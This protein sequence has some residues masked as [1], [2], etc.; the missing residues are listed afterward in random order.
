MSHP[1]G[2]DYWFARVDF[3]KK[4][5]R[6]GEVTLD[7]MRE[8]LDRLGNPQDYLR[9]AHVAGTKGKGSTAAMLESI[10]RAAGLRTGLFT[11]P[12]LTRVHERIRLGSRPIADDDLAV[13]LTEIRPAIESLE[14]EGRPPTFFEIATALAYHQ[15]AK[16]AVDLAVMEVG[17]GGRFDATNVCRPVVCVITSVSYD[18]TAILGDRL[19]QIAFEKCGIIKSGVPVASGVTIEEPAEVVRA[20]CRDRGCELLEIGRDMSFE[21]SPGR[22]DAAGRV[23]QSRIDVTWDGNE[24][25]FS[26]GLLGRHQAAN[27]SLALL[28]VRHLARAGVILPTDAIR[29]GLSQVYW[30]ARMELFAGPPPVVLDCAHNVASAAAVVETLAESFS[31]SKRTLLFAASADKDVEGMLREYA[32]HFG[33]FV[34][35]RFR[36]NPRAVGPDQLA[37]WFARIRPGADVLL[38]DDP[39]EAL[40]AARSDSCAGLVVATGSV[41]LAGDLWPELAKPRR[42]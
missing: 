19:A 3:E 37:Q 6:R 38:M 13:A 8:L 10:A 7:R 26:V 36:D 25:G 4:P 11:S 18:H 9:I 34:F 40:A 32:P 12:H 42:L 1:D 27:A 15:F 35:T 39:L 23:Q 5:A 20:T 24:S 22:V 21:H 28:A 41:F 30:P 14:R 31:A 2:L 29:R 16:E 33:R 17:L